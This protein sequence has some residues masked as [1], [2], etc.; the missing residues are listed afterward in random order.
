MLQEQGD[1]MFH[2]INTYTKSAQYP[3]LN[4]ESQFRL[5]RTGGSTLAMLN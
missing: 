2:I 3:D 5:Q 4:A 1:T